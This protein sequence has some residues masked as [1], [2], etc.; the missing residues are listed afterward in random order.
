MSF[1]YLLSLPYLILSLVGCKCTKNITH[2][3]FT[4]SFLKKKESSH[5]KTN[6]PIT[7]YRKNIHNSNFLSNFAFVLWKYVAASY[8]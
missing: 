1:S 7:K 5:K 4:R 6:L 3:T 2:S 8:K